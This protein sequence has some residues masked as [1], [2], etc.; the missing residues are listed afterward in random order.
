MAG[1]TTAKPKK[2]TIVVGAILVWCSPPLMMPAI[3]WPVMSSPMLTGKR[4]LT[5]GSS[6]KTN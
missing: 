2:L 6:T 3:R 4:S 5:Q 1:R